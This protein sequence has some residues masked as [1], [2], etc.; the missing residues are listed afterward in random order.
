M[1]SPSLLY[2]VASTVVPSDVSECDINIALDKS[3]ILSQLEIICDVKPFSES[4]RTDM[5][6]SFLLEQV[7]LIGEQAFWGNDCLSDCTKSNGWKLNILA[8]PASVGDEVYGFLIYKV[9]AKQRNLQIQYIA[10]ANKYRR[11]GAGSKLLKA[12]QKYA[13][14]V[15]TR[16]YVEKIA[17]AC[18]PEAVE[19]YQ[20]H[21]FRKCK[22]ILPDEHEKEVILPNGNIERQ[23]PLQFLMEWKVPGKSKR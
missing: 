2:R 10:V 5:R 16:S 7:R 20:K 3:P 1:A 12:L 4:A 6:T 18:V 23:I 15:L 9:D 11:H 21:N 13:I 17:C 19:F 14:K 22:R 8:Q